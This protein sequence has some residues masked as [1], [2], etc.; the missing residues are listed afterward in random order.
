MKKILFSL[1]ISMF[2]VG[3]AYAQRY[4]T[5]SG[6]I[7]FYSDTPVET[8]EAH[9]R[10]VNSALDAGTGDFIFKVLMRGFEFE[11]ALMQEHFNENYVESHKYPNATFVGKVVNLEEIDFG[12]DG[13]YIAEVEGELSIHGVTNKVKE[14]G[15]FEVKGDKITGKAKFTIL[16]ADYNIKIPGAVIENI[17]EEIE[18]TVNVELDKLKS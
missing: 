5:K 13:T 12:K 17:A 18:I 10:Q 6:H 11:K 7:M 3:G 4:V 9:N 15:S 2:L 1:L 16:V 14:M 8:I